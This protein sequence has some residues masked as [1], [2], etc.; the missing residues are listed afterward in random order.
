MVVLTS[1]GAWAT[2]LAQPVG[3]ETHRT[4]D[5]EVGAT[6]ATHLQISTKAAP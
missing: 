1:P 3:L 2:R 5:Q 6:Y 4:A